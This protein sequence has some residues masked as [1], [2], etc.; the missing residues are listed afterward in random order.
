MVLNFLKNK[1]SSSLFNKR[2]RLGG[3]EF[4][5]SLTLPLSTRGGKWV[6]LMV[7]LLV[8]GAGCNVRF[9]TGGEDGGVFLSKDR[10]QNWEQRVA[11]PAVGKIKATT[12]DNIDVNRIIMSPKDSRVLYAATNNNG[13]YQ[14]SYQGDTWKQLFAGRA[15]VDGWV[16]NEASQRLF[17]ALPTQ[18]VMSEDDGQQWKLMYEEQVPKVAITVL[19]QS[20][21]NPRLVFAGL[22][23]GRLLVSRDKGVQWAR[24]TQFERERVIELFPSA[25]NADRLFVVT[26]QAVYRSDNGGV[27]WINLTE[28]LATQFSG[29][30]QNINAAAF[31][32][33]RGVDEEMIV[34][35]SSYGLAVTGN[36]GVSWFVPSLIQPPQ[37]VAIVSVAIDPKNRQILYYATASA[38]YRTVNSGGVWHFLPLPSARA[39]VSLVIDWYDPKIMYLGVKR[40]K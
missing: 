13:L 18:I 26:S 40:V 27:S 6:L 37:R 22:S 28:A 23:D 30:N 12:I 33:G 25:H 21:R 4:I 3:G 15:V 5:P 19:R 9:R 7:A 14:S 29:I 16:D 20:P 36:G 34:F 24:L 35:A 2:G 39:P 11:V 38:L 17:M 1:F 32:V 8:I 10:G 31:Q